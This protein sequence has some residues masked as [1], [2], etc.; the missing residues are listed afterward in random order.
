MDWTSTVNFDS[1]WMSV[2]DFSWG[3]SVDMLTVI[4]LNIFVGMLVMGKYDST[5]ASKESE[6]I[7]T[8]EKIPW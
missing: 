4:T 8:S 3:T 2:P 6:I 7:L 5:W 1:D